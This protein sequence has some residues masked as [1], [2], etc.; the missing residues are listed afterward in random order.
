[1]TGYPLRGR[2]SRGRSR[3]STSDLPGFYPAVYPRSSYG[4]WTADRGLPL[5]DQPPACAS[6]NPRRT[7]LYQQ[8]A[9]RVPD[10][11]RTR[12]VPANRC[13][14]QDL[15][16]DSNLCNRRRSDATAAGCTVSAHSRS[17]LPKI[18]PT[19][20]VSNLTWGQP[21]LRR[22]ASALQPR[23][24]SFSR[25]SRSVRNPEVS[26]M[27]PRIWAFS[28]R[29]CAVCFISCWRTGPRGTS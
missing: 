13:R 27:R 4:G 19:N 7:L 8:G 15:R 2:S 20:S 5:S 3:S 25:S 17:A 6:R 28:A 14:N 29:N 21:A 24:D 12:R 26:R 10:A 18:D 23:R 1:M 16:V 9:S 11:A 22:E